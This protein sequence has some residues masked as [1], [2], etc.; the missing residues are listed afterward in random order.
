M[1][2][3]L[4]IAGAYLLGSVPFGFM[5]ARLFGVKDIRAEGSGNIG[6]TNVWR[7]AGPVA[8]LLVFVGDVGKGIL[9]VLIA[10]SVFNSMAASEYICL[11]AAIAV[12]I[13]HI[14]PLFLGFKGGKGVN[15]ALGTMLV[16]RPLEVMLALAVFIIVV[17]VS[18]Y[19]SLGSLLAA[20]VFF[21]AM[22]SEY[23]LLPGRVHPVFPVMASFIFV[24]IVITHR[25][26]IKR[27]LSRT[28][29]RFSLKSKTS[30]AKSNA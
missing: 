28:E 17:A 30:G 16:L 13:G 18:R 4:V 1:N 20:F 12:I 2:I 24:I 19:I 26:N 6:M 8:A 7:T 10:Y 29:N 3:F 27:L 9:A 15:T 22:I 21:L 11:G 5:I 25:S 14:F 23:L